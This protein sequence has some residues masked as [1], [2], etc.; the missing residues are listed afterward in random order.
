MAL[1][2]VKMGS[3]VF[4]KSFEQSYIKV[5]KSIE[6]KVDAMRKYQ[7]YRFK[8]IYLDEQIF[9]T[10]DGEIK[11]G[12]LNV[13]GLLDGGHAEYL[14]SDHNLLNLDIL[15]LAETKLN[16][17]FG[18]AMIKQKLSSWKLIGRYDCEDGTKHMGLMLLSN[19]NSNGVDKMQ[20][21]S[22]K[23][24]KREKEPQIEGLVVRMRNKIN[25]G[26]IYSRSSP[27]NSEV[28]GICKNF[29]DCNILMGDFNLSHKNAE[30]QLKVV[31]LCHGRKV[32]ALKEITRTMSNNQLDYVLIDDNMMEYCFTTSYNNFMSDHKAI[33]VR[34][35]STETKIRTKIKE[36]QLFDQ[37]SHLKNRQ[38]NQEEIIETIERKNTQKVSEVGNI[39]KRRFRNP[40]MSTC[41]LNSCLQLILTAMEYDEYAQQTFN[42]ELGKNC[43]LCNQMQKLVHLIQQTLKT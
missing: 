42:S 34:I 1:T 39:F 11:I 21:I 41:W 37:E 22:Y 15:A 19:N 2:R 38:E 26:F 14:N 29:E 23:V 27:T 3:K 6:E 12:Y 10:D 16:Q 28:K 33:V 5:N 13:N 43:L 24:A 31:K 40:D 9:D 35:G 8:K 32:N 30:D 17:R 25:I 36:R 20:S 7:Q 18:T 4:L